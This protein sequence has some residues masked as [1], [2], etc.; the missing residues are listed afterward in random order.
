MNASN[1][2][3][4]FSLTLGF[5]ALLWFT[6][7]LFR[8]IREGRYNMKE[9]RAELDKLRAMLEH[10]M[11]DLQ[12]RLLLTESRWKDVNHLLL[13]SQRLSSS[14][15]SLKKQKVTM[16]SY[17]KEMGFS[18]EDLIIDPNLVFVLTPFHEEHQ[19]TFEIIRNV[20]SDV[21]LKCL[22]GDE[23]YIESDILIHILRQLLKAR[24]LIVNIE[25]RNPNVFY[26]LGLAHAFGKPTILL[27]KSV[28]EAPFDVKSKRIIFYKHPLE[29]RDLLRVELTKALV[30]T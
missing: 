28:Q 17:L 23:Q 1:I 6:M 27:S 3:L 18:E 13:D 22:R 16:T 8:Q 19:Q 9:N 5:S 4:V 12:E 7:L 24:M 25:G 2:I 14:D 26:E 10:R 20:C 11:Y 29:L 30:E 21:G 15:T